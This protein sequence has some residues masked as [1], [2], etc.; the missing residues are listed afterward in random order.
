MRPLLLV[1]LIPFGADA[2]CHS[3]GKARWPIKSSVP[4]HAN[5]SKSKNVA[6]TDLVKLSFPPGAKHGD[7]QF[8]SDRIPSFPNSLIVKEGDFLSVKGF[9]FLVA[10]EDNDCEY[11]IQLSDQPRTTSDPPK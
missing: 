4:D 9:L 2:V 10:T 8:Q 6:L 7:P 5:F 1:L 11:H 3:P